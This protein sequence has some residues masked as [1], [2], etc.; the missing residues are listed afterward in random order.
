MNLPEH[1]AMVAKLSAICTREGLKPRDMAAVCE[2]AAMGGLSAFT[3]NTVPDDVIADRLHALASKRRELFDAGAP[4]NTHGL[5]ADFAAYLKNLLPVW[6]TL[7]PEVKIQ[8]KR[9]FDASKTAK[10]TQLEQIQAELRVRYGSDEAATRSMAP[11]ERNRLAHASGQ[12]SKPAK[13]APTAVTDE[14][15]NWPADK[16]LDYVY[17]KAE[18]AKIQ[19]STREFDQTRVKAILA[20][21]G[22]SILAA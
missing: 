18:L 9:D 15:R 4:I 20:R 10:P 16:K 6:S 1:D 21:F 13:P 22:R 2:A 12:T 5:P 17:A 19:H 11:E 8:L 3:L 7:R 14:T